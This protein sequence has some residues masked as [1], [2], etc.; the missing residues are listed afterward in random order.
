MIFETKAEK[1]RG[2]LNNIVLNLRSLINNANNT[3]PP[4]IEGY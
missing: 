1:I 4:S 3:G 2:K